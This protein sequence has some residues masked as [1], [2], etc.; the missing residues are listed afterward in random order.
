M[1]VFA[2][3]YIT[4]NIS[5]K[6]YQLICPTIFCAKSGRFFAEYI[7]A[8]DRGMSQVEFFPEV[9]EPA[10]GGGGFIH[11]VDEKYAPPLPPS[12]VARKFMGCLP[13]P[14]EV[15]AFFSHF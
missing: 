7:Y 14:L 6:K 4:S 15:D 13:R 10:R 8:G 3:P 9:W 12:Q 2:A 5:E 1:L 11:G